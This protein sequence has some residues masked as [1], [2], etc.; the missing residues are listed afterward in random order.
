MTFHLSSSPNGVTESYG[1]TENYYGV[2][3]HVCCSVIRA[4]H[5]KQF[6]M[7]TRPRRILFVS[8]ALARS[9]SKFSFLTK[10][11]EKRKMRP[12]KKKVD[13]KR[14]NHLITNRICQRIYS[15]PLLAHSLSKCFFDLDEGKKKNS[16]QKKKVDKKGNNHCITNR[17]RRRIY[18]SPLLT[19]S[20]SNSK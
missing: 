12:R 15:S 20:L 3:V 8:L 10:T 16:T 7:P 19:H 6:W 14:N 4:K 5:K 9:L 13:E 1:V 11:R 2:I 17:I 18:S